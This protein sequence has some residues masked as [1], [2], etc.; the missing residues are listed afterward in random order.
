MPNRRVANCGRR[1][2]EVPHYNRTAAGCTAF[3]TRCRSGATLRLVVLKR[4]IGK[5]SWS[6]VHGDCA[7]TGAATGT[8]RALR[9]GRNDCSRSTARYRGWPTP[10]LEIASPNAVPGSGPIASLP[11]SARLKLNPLC[12]IER[13][14]AL[15]MAPPSAS[16]AVGELQ[17]SP[18]RA[19][20]PMNS[21]S[22]IPAIAKLPNAPPIPG[23]TGDGPLLSS[24][25]RAELPVN[26]EEVTWSVPKFAMP[27]D[28]RLHCRP[29]RLH[30]WRG[31]AAR[32][33]WRRAGV[34]Q[35]GAA[36]SRPT[37][38]RQS[39]VLQERFRF[40]KRTRSNVADAG[41]LVPAEQTQ[42][43]TCHTFR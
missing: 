35:A 42:P 13:S 1:R 7:A 39:Q 6:K 40:R 3:A 25:P 15:A 22:T 19:R 14:P 28:D 5:S 18:P 29:S 34:R 24:P 38:D 26:S 31:L 16:A 33:C 2:P 21:L 4:A 32:H 37:P 20:F 43:S 36:S 12:E 8:P 10:P 27:G 30:W 17:L 41:T 9:C 11:P 23:A